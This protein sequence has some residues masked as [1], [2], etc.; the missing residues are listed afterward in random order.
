MTGVL[1]VVACVA[2]VAVL[3]AVRFATDDA[4][5]HYLGA[6]GWPVHGQAAYAV[7]SGPIAASPGRS[8]VPIASVAKVMT[9]LV[10]LRAAPLAPGADGFRLT[11]T[12]RDVADT[13]ARAADDESIVPVTNGEVLTERQALTA[14]LLPSANNVAVMLA[15]RVA[16][17]VA[18]FVARMNA[19]ARRLGMRETTYTD[20]SGLLAS[21]RSTAGDQ[22][23]LAEAALRVPELA[24]LVSLR[25]ARLPVAGTVRNTDFLLGTRGFVGIKT[26]SDDAAGGCFMFRARRAGVV[27]TGVV[28]GQRG[29]NLIAAALY[30][31]AQLVDRVAAGAGNRPIRPGTPG[32]PSRGSTP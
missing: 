29:H 9:A 17:T 28:L 26:G 11:V 21:T 6:A 4:R 19:T 2:A 12:Q 13:D 24:R 32:R 1:A 25:S 10:V 8:P 22:V 16:G 30:A 27:V 18:R 20:P 14:L 23:R 7:D 5:R 3:A 31:A 15:R